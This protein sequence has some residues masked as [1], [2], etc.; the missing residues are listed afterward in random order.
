M[1]IYQTLDLVI[2]DGMI[3]QK[4]ADSWNLV[5]ISLYNSKFITTSSYQQIYKLLTRGQGS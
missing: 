1:C 5:G 3:T 2:A 4:L